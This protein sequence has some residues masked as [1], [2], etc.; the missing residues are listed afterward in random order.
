MQEK[1]NS[2]GI[3]QQMNKHEQTEL[4]YNKLCHMPKLRISQLDLKYV[5][6]AIHINQIKISSQPGHFL[7]LAPQ[8]VIKFTAQPSLI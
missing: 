1:S 3:C 4:Q 8:I 2:I 7:F 6:D 5:R